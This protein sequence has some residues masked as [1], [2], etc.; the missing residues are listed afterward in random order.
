MSSF[1]ANGDFGRP[2]LLVALLF[3]ATI[4]STFIEDEITSFRLPND[5]VPLH[6]SIDITTKIHEDIFD[7]NGTVSVEV[8]VINATNKIVLHSKDL[9]IVGLSLV[10]IEN[11]VQLDNVVY[12]LLDHYSML[13]VYSASNDV[14]VD[15]DAFLLNAGKKY[16]LSI[17]YTGHMNNVNNNLTF[18]IYADKY[19]NAAN[20]TV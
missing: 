19:K 9:E 6:Y 18:G 16:L 2:L 13:V 8:L 20:K 5:T 14:L 3:L 11:K 4:G 1:P 12:K 7:F 15:D 17:E 10:D